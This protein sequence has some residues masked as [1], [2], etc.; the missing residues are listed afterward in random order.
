MAILV[1]QAFADWRVGGDEMTD[2]TSQDA[3]TIDREHQ[4]QMS[5][6][7][8]LAAVLDQG[9][10]ATEL[11]SALEDYSRAHFLS[12][13]LLMRLHAYPDFDGHSAD[14]EKLIESIER[15]SSLAGE[16]EA[17]RR[18]CGELGVALGRHIATRD[19][20]LAAYIEALPTI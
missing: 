18:L 14:H 16:R 20:R 2:Q 4:V 19:K 1:P 5:L 10:D 13:E 3:A 15:M 8:S 12:E 11:V 17:L 6:L 9:G 7:K